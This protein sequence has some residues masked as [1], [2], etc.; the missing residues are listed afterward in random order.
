M[1]EL[2]IHRHE[3]RDEFFASKGRLYW[4]A[5][6]D[7]WVTADED[8][9]KSVFKNSDFHVA[10]YIAGFR[11]INEKLGVDFATTINVLS[12]SPV[13][14]E[15]TKHREARKKSALWIKQHLD[16]AVRA[17]DERLQSTLKYV[18]E[19]Q[20]E[21][22]LMQE[23]IGPAINASMHA[24]SDVVTD[25][26][27]SEE[28]CSQ[29][30][31]RLLSLNRR[32]RLNTKLEKALESAP[33]SC[34]Q[35]SRYFQASLT[36]VGSDSIL[37]GLAESV[38]DHLEKNVETRLCDILWSDK[39][40][41]TSVPYVERICARDCELEGQKIKAGN[42][43]RIY[44]FPFERTEPDSLF[45]MGKH[46]CLGKALTL[47][48]WKILTGQ[49]SEIPKVMRVCRVDYRKSDYLFRTPTKLKVKISNE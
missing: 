47:E 36:T 6:I 23:C 16:A 22:D 14:W 32:K 37:G 39:I 15:G 41:R 42:R 18:S 9:V 13:V 46:V 43:I 31:D 29:I 4:S 25:S 28:S 44:L 7:S 5:A 34:T 48:I 19:R 49:L 21:F 27:D 8:L 30:F 10:D 3:E 38:I 45:G 35:A 11:A 20:A 24:L 33:A 2:Q 40:S 1:N 12:H 26:F 17:F